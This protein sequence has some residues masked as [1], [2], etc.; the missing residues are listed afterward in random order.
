ME[1]CIFC[2]ISKGEISSKKYY[3]DE[4]FF[5]IADISPK[6]KKHYLMI[7]KHHYKLLEEQNDEDNTVLAKMFAKLPQIAKELGLVNGYRIII[8]QGDDGCQEVPHLHVHIL[9]GE[10]LNNF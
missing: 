3:E 2:K 7:P 10:K 6:A 1:N 5:V 9:G 4:D 8:N